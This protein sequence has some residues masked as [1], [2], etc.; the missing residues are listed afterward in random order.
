MTSTLPLD[1]TGPSP[2]AAPEIRWG[3]LAP[4]GIAHLFAR[5]VLEH[6]KSPIV[7][8]GSRDL[9]RAR[10]FAEEFAIPTAYGSYED[11]LSDDDVDA[12]YIASPH[13][14]H[15]VH[16]R[17]AIAAGKHI[18]V[19]KA[20]THN[21]FEAESIFYAA[22]D[23]GLYVQE[24]MW[25]RFLPQYYTLRALL[26][27]RIIGKVV[28]V[29]AAHGQAISQVPRLAQP[30]LAGGAL[31]DLGVYPIS[32]T[33]HLLGRPREIHA[34]GHLTPSGVDATVGITMTYRDAIAS[35][36]TTMLSRSHN[37]AEISGTKGRITLSD[38]FY[39]PGTQITVHLEGEEPYTYASDVPGGYHFQA[40][41]FARNVRAGVL[42]SPLMTWQNTIDVMH[43]MDEIRRQLG[44]E[45]P[46]ERRRTV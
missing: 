9:D 23:A 1:P 18:L 37:I 13:S 2:L 3:I 44:V 41:E 24:A 45:F 42:E 46:G 31:L 22:R 40:A 32:F 5:D 30:E 27:R 17:A 6:T 10:A 8:V 15:Y 12:V 20:F 36:S 43:I 33:H 4:G 35:L 21:A 39:H 19:E 29:Y 38:T 7:A 26:A 14:H 28:H 34:S 16:A 25:T 11:L